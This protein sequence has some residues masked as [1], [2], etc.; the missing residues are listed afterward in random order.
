VEGVRMHEAPDYT[1]V[2]FDISGPVEYDLFTLDNPR[3]VVI[4]LRDT[5]ARPGFD[6]AL[7]NSGWGACV[8]AVRAAPRGSAYRV[9]LDLARAVDPKTFKLDPVAPYGH[10]LV[11]DLYASSPQQSASVAP[12]EETAP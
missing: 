10:R 6:P 4:D 12:R 1:R 5:S 9:V 3:R 2:V 8:T 7:A 11:V